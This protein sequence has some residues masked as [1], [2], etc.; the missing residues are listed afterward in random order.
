M[1]NSFIF[2]M[3]KLPPQISLLSRIHEWKLLMAE[4]NEICCEELSWKLLTNLYFV[5]DTYLENKI[6]GTKR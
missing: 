5:F 3:M 4:R 1:D 6:T 2:Y